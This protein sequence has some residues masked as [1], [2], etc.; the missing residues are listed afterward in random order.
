MA[1]HEPNVD[2]QDVAR[3]ATLLPE[4]E[5]A[6]SDDPRSQAEEILA[7]SEERAAERD[8]DVAD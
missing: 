5:A 7:E 2:E 6:G 4:E 1:E 3:R 8:E